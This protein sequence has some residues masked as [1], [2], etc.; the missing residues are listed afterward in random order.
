MEKTGIKEMVIEEI[1]S[2]AKKN[3]VKKVIL[4]G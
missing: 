1:Q 4:F 3:N 2:I